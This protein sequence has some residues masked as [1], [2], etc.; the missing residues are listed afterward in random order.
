MT[1]PS[2][3]IGSPLELT[4]WATGGQENNPA[5][6]IG[7]VD[8]ELRD[9]RSKRLDTVR[10]LRTR[11]GRTPGVRVPDLEVAVLQD[12]DVRVSMTAGL[13]GLETKDLVPLPIAI[14]PLEVA[15]ARDLNVPL[16]VVF[17]HV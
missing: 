11:L 9:E 17:A 10:T 1:E 12:A 5:L 15:V 8:L 4:L 16:A 2:T 3:L 6:P 13:L 7:S 14:G